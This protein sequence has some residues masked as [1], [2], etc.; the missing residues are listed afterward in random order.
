MGG[1]LATVERVFPTFAARLR[2]TPRAAWDRFAIVVIYVAVALAFTDVLTTLSI[3]ILVW[4][5][6]QVFYRRNPKVIALLISSVLSLLAFEWVGA[7]V[8]R[9][10]LSQ[11]HS[12][13]VEHRMQP[14]AYPW[15][16]SDGIRC[17]FEATDFS[18][19]TFNVICIGDSFCYG[20]LLDDSNE[21][22][23]NQLEKLAGER[24]PDWRLRTINF[25]WTS[26]SPII[27]SRVLREIGPKYKP[28]LVIY[29][30]DMTDFHDDLRRRMGLE[31]VGTP[32]AEFM[33]Q[34]LGAAHW[35]DE[36]RRRFRLREWID[37]ALSR[38]ELV[39]K[40]RFFITSRPLSQN[41]ELMEETARNLMETERI[42]REEL[43]CRFILFMFPRTYQYSNRESPRNWESIRYE[44]L[45]PYV[46]EPFVWLGELKERV[47]FPVYSLYD[48][49]KNATEFPLSFEDD[50]HWTPA[51]HRLVA[52]ALLR[53]LEGEGYFEVDRR[54]V[55]Q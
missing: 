14:H 18:A 6:F 44:V 21:T 10:R 3:G 42:C 15:V 9:W 16:N 31:N 23:P 20:E 32:P 39:P 8:I 22:F 5:I 35:V 34:Q 28:K 7:R 19:D 52:R 38:Q 50:P 37:S 36:L 24:H 33:I 53:I 26:S 4:L 46:M 2:T 47:S 48:D 27:T 55:G 54:P 43:G 30:L 11:T 41:R 13:D 40:D 49:F 17:Q 45:G 1:L 25:G 12:P 51:G 29:C